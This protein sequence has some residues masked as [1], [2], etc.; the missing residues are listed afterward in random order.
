MVIIDER[1]E[2]CASEA[3]ITENFNRL[4]RLIDATPSPT[5]EDI[6]KM[7]VVNE[8]GEYELKADAAVQ[9][10]KI[11]DP[12]TT[13]G[14]INEM[15]NGEGGINEVGRVVL[16]NV[17]ALGANAY[18]C[19]IFLDV[20]DGAGTYKITDLVKLRTYS[21][22]YDAD[23]LLSTILASMYD[24]ATRAEIDNLQEQINS[25]IDPVLGDTIIFNKVVDGGLAVTS[26]SG[27]LTFV[28]TDE[29]KFADAVGECENKEYLLTFDGANWLY[30]DVAVTDF[31]ITVTG[32]PITGEVMHVVMT[33]EEIEHTVVD[34]TPTGTNVT[35]P[36]DSTITEFQIVEQ[37]YVPDAQVYDEPES[38]L[39]ITPSHRLSAGKYYV[40]NVAGAT[41][42]YWCNYK[43]LY[44]CFE[45]LHDIVATGET[46]DITLRFSSRGARE[47]EGDARGVYQL[48]C[49]PYCEATG[50][51]YNSDTVEFVGQVAAPSSEYTDIR[52]L[53][54]FTTDQSLDSEGIIY[55]NLGHVCYGNNE[56][57]VSNLAQ[58][59]NSSEKRM[60][61][62]RMHKND[63]VTGLRNVRGCMWGLDPRVKE[64]I[65]TAV[66]SREHG[67]GDEYTKG[68]IHTLEMDAFCLSMVE[69]SFNIQT[70]EGVPTALYSSY[71]DNTLV[72][73]A[74]EERGKARRKGLAPQDYRWAG[75]AYVGYSYGSRMVSATGAND[76]STAINGN[77][78]ASAY[79]LKS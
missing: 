11:D 59:L 20:T 52:T 19:T 7:I 14:D 18:M 65:A 23:L 28:V 46:G 71:T 42:D 24:I 5:L 36:K 60:S 76:R 51:L 32:T 61:P 45:I 22:V 37:T 8:N 27:E 26:T 17:A 53:T 43:R 40:Y 69:M 49:K 63:V 66:I 2:D 29:S 6:N 33:I 56:F 9:P 41:G 12:S 73:T 4:L 39:C 21:G 62:V 57:G 79:I 64:K 48:Y 75:S 67:L 30:N 77:R 16:F 78:F 58:R 25:L 13:L 72:N 55:N 74:I 38:A 3:E 15:L 1:L 47:T 35:H 50:A 68:E 54:D 10:V 34:I 44:Y 31:G 70:D